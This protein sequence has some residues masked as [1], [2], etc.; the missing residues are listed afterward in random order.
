MNHFLPY[1]QIQI[2]TPQQEE[3]YQNIIRFWDN[4]TIRIPIMMQLS[5]WLMYRLVPRS[6]MKKNIE[7]MDRMIA[8][9]LHPTEAEYEKLKK[10]VQAGVK[11]KNNPLYKY[12]PA[13]YAQRKFMKELQNKGYNDIFIPNMIALSPK[14]REYHDA[15]TS[16]NNRICQEL[17]LYYDTDFH[18]VQR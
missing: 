17:G 15:L 11:M 7:N 9:Y 14:Y 13:G 16:L 3:A 12:S 18:L 8:M 2:D 4:T 6:S 10:Q 5:S 1:L